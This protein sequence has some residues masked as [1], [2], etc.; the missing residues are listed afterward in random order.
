MEDDIFGVAG[1]TVKSKRTGEL[2]EAST[3][4][5]DRIAC[6]ELPRI[7][8][9]PVGGLASAGIDDGGLVAVSVAPEVNRSV[10]L[11]RRCAKATACGTSD[12]AVE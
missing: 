10:R 2:E 12:D 3:R 5:I 1:S 8:K 11:C 6:T 4:L 9:H 7:I